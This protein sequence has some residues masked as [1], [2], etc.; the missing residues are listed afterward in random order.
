MGPPNY[1]SSDFVICQQ[2]ETLQKYGNLRTLISEVIY[3]NMY[4]VGQ[5]QNKVN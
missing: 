3:K 4:S 1:R 2:Q 5:L